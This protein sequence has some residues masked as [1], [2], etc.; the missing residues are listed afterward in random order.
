MTARSAISL[1]ASTEARCRVSK[2]FNM[3]SLPAKDYTGPKGLLTPH[4]RNAPVIERNLGVV[5]ARPKKTAFKEPQHSIAS[6]ACLLISGE[7]RKGP[8]FHVIR[9]TCSRRP[10]VNVPCVA[11]VSIYG[12]NLQF[13]SPRICAHSCL[14]CY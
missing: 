5:L 4:L 6:P 11:L 2:H 1:H 14:R 8:S 9:N 3:S 12:L 10:H 7:L 13:S